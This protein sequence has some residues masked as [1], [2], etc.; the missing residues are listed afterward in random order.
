[1][2]IN[3]DDLDALEFVQTHS[4]RMEGD[5]PVFR[6]SGGPIFDITLENDLRPSVYIWVSPIDP[7]LYDVLY[8]GKAGFGISRRL[9]QH[10]GGFTH[11]QT[12]RNNRRL[13]TEWLAD[14]RTIEV[15]RR[16]SAVQNVLGQD[17]SLYSSEEQAL[18]E[19]F[20]PL[21][22]RAVF[23][24][25]SHKK[26]V[27]SV[28]SAGPV[29]LKVAAAEEVTLSAVN[30]SQQ[31][32]VD[33][34]DIPFGDEVAAFLDSLDTEKR[35]QFLRLG[36]LLQSREPAAGQKIVGG[37]T[38][39]PTGYEGKP[40][41]VFGIIGKGGV[42]RRRPGWIP[43]IDTEKAPLTVIFPPNAQAS[44]IDP[45]WISEGKTGDWRPRDLGH[46]LEN[47]DMYLK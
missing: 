17:I 18:C 30:A 10:Q 4:I 15:Y 28:P 6:L 21:W 46:F 8:I 38:G 7:L 31:T 44:N 47:P 35:S 9:K 16:V 1:M 37:Y 19:R 40:L 24:K 39:Q 25:T 22:N 36:E 5:M 41:Y 34:N 43:L 27:K 12:G 32:D 23:P 29:A 11:S 20:S 14:G 33:F 3:F 13:I 26:L 45:T 42:A 2:T